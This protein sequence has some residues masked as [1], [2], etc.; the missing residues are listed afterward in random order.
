MGPVLRT[1]SL[2]CALALTAGSAYALIYLLLYAAGFK[3][4]MAAGAAVAV[5]FGL[6]WIWADFINADPRPEK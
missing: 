6:Y 3:I 1:I 2:V 5:F 4:W